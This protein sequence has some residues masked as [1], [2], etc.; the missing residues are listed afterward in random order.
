MENP[1]KPIQI[2]CSWLNNIYHDYLISYWI[3]KYMQCS[4]QFQ[5]CQKRFP[6]NIQL[7]QYKMSNSSP[8]CE[9]AQ[10]LECSVN[11]FKYWYHIPK[12]DS[13]HK[14][15]YLICASEGSLA[16]DFTSFIHNLL[17]LLIFE[18]KIIENDLQTTKQVIWWYNMDIHIKKI[19]LQIIL[20]H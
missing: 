20:S 12:L 10:I 1:I 2:Y 3:R 5:F 4:F 14:I 8:V 16:S 9:C 19:C 7:Q 11:F 13:V 18:N 6:W 15:I 17:A